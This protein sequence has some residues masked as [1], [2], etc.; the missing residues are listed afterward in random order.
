M[1]SMMIDTM[2]PIA[3]TCNG[4]SVLS[5]NLFEFEFKSRS[6]GTHA[7][8]FFNEFATR[9][10]PV[11][12]LTS[13]TLHHSPI[14]RCLFLRFWVPSLLQIRL[15]FMYILRNSLFAAKLRT[16]SFKSWK[17]DYDVIIAISSSREMCRT[18]R[19]GRRSFSFIT[20]F[21]CEST[22]GFLHTS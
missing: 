14:L 15:T 5:M 13:S 19:V 11:S 4:I 9:A 17:L 7:R 21:C 16:P 2:I 1:T 10:A 22:A 6:A 20:A 12:S 18:C 3:A 8:T